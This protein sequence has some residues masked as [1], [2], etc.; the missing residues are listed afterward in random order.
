MKKEKTKDD[1]SKLLIFE[2]WNDDPDS[3]L[4]G[5][6]IG[7][8]ETITVLDRLTGFGWRDVETGYMDEHGDFWLASG[9]FDIRRIELGSIEEAIELIK[10]NANTC[11]PKNNKENK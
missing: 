10:V 1:K 9:N 7:R 8:L 2:E 4:F 11:I 6:R 3:N 5:M